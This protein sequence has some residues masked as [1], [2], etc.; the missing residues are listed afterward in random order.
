[1]DYSRV[2]TYV[3]PQGLKDFKVR[4]SAC[5]D[6]DCIHGIVVLMVKISQLTPFVTPN[7]DK[8]YGQ[9]ETKAGP[10]DPEIYLNRWKRENA[11]D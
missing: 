8:T 4:L 10:R 5:Y 7:M 1:M 6:P 3:V 2:R 9:Y 11:V